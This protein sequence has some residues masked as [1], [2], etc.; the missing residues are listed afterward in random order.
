MTKMTY[1]SDKRYYNFKTL[2]WILVLSA[3]TF[4][5]QLLFNPVQST[6][7]VLS[8][9]IFI[10]TL[11]SMLV[12]RGIV[13]GY[14]QNSIEMNSDSLTIFKNDQ[15]LERFSFDKDVISYIKLKITQ[16]SIWPNEKQFIEIH[17]QEGISTYYFRIA[18]Q[19]NHQKVVDLIPG[20]KNNG[21][22]VHQL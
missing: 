20:W 3:S 22:Q 18:S 19:Y 13:K 21:I 14:T 2:Q 1:I 11:A 10:V 12:V 17:T 7:F 6:A 5:A 9:I 16:E 15:I 4:S 8:S